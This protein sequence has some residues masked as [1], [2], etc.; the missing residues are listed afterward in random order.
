VRVDPTAA[1]APERIITS[2]NLAPPPGLV[3]GA[4]GAV[5]PALLAQLRSAWEAL[6]NRWNQWVMNYSRGQQLDLLKDLGFRSPSWEDLALLL[7]GALS[8]LALAGAGWAW[9]DRHRVDPWV[10][11]R[12]D[13]HAALRA[14]GLPAAAHDPPRALARRVRERY[15]AEG[16][17]FAALI[18][19][20]ELQRYTR[21]ALERPDPALT[22]A[23]AAHARRLATRIA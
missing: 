10:R 18:E 4:I 2:R 6:D 17:A 11:Q 16:E 20:L 15:A 1:V 13:L 9:W 19:R 23:F 14:L 8:T 7:I 22:R 21:Q 3:A 5:N 12:E